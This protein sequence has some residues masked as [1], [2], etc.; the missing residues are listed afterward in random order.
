MKKI[1]VSSKSRKMFCNA[2]LQH[3]NWQVDYPTSRWAIYTS[4]ENVLVQQLVD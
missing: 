3:A 2:I 1:K 4:I